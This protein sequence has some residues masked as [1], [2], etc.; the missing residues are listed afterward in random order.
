MGDGRAE[1]RSAIGDGGQAAISLTPDTDGAHVHIF[2]SSK[3]EGL[4]VGNSTVYYTVNT[5]KGKKM[6]DSI[7]AGLIE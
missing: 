3:L 4:Y 2:E 1:G 5:S 6:N 7:V